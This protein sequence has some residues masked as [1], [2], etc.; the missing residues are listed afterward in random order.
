V[1]RK[2]GSDFRSKAA[3]PQAAVPL[4]NLIPSRPDDID[5]DKS[6]DGRNIPTE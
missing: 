1:T 3:A 5:V 4:P 6:L 2:D